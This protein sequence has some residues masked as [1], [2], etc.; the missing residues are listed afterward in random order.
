[1]A[2]KQ[3]IQKNPD[4]LFEALG[5]AM[6]QWQAI[7]STLYEAFHNILDADQKYSAYLYYEIRSPERKVTI[8]SDLFRLYLGEEKYK[9]K[10][11]DAFKRIGDLVHERNNLAHFCVPAAVETETNAY[12]VF[13]NAMY[14]PY[15]HPSYDRLEKFEYRT[16]D[17]FSL[18]REFMQASWPITELLN[19]LFPNRTGP[20]KSH[21]LISRRPQRRSQ[22]RGDSRSKNPLP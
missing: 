10:A 15:L 14:F 12:K 13:S 5:T 1:M 22:R 8:V 3:I 21:E 6:S 11:A 4:P 17:I 18:G 9:E 16:D 2:T 20:T 19:E 7:E